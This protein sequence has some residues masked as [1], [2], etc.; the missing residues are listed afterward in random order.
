MAELFRKLRQKVENTFD[1]PE[2]EVVIRFIKLFCF[3][4]L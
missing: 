1:S 4:I 2:K 3:E